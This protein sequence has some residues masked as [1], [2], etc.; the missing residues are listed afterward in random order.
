MVGGGTGEQEEEHKNI[1][2]MACK[3]IFAFFFFLA[4]SSYRVLIVLIKRG[5]YLR[6]VKEQQGLWRERASELL[7]RRI[8]LPF[9][10]AW[11]PDYP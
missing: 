11:L 4:T 5:Y 3:I 1:S 10:P 6:L 8:G 7:L 2:G 9:V